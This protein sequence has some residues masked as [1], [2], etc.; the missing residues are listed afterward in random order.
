MNCITTST[1]SFSLNGE[2]V[3]HVQ[4]YRGLRQGDPLSPYLFLIC[5]EGLSRLLRYEEGVGNLDGLRLTRNSPAVSHLLFADDSLLFCRANYQSAVAIHRILDTYHKASGQVLN[6]NKSVMSFSPNTTM[7]AQNFFAHTLHMPIT[8]CHERYL[9]LPSYSG[10]DKQELFSHIKEKVLKLLHAWNEK[11]FSV[12]GK[13]VL[14][15]AVVQSIPTYAM[16]CFKLTNKFC[17][18]LESMMANFWWGTNQ[19]GTKIHWIRWNSL[20]KSK[21]EG[22]MGFRSFFHFNQALL[23]KQAWKIFN[24]PDSLLSRLLKHRYFSTTSF[25]DANIGHSPSYTWQSICWG[26]ELLVKGMRFKIC[27]GHRIVCAT[28]PWIPS[29]TNFKPV[30]YHGPPNMSVS[31]L[32][33]EQ[34]VWNIELLNSFFQPIDV[35]KILTIPLSFFAS[36]D[37]LIWHHSTSGSY[38]VKSGFH[39]ASSLED[40]DA[41]SPSD[42]NLT[43]WKFFWSLNL[44]PKIRIFAWKVYHNIIPTAAALHRRKI[45]DSAACSL[46]TSN[47]E[48]VG[49]ALFD[50]KHARR[51]WQESKFFIDFQ[52]AKAMQNGDYFQLLSSIYSQEDFELLVCI[53]WGVWTDRNKIFHGGQARLSSSIVA[54]AT[55]FHHDYNR[56]KNQSTSMTTTSPSTDRPASSSRRHEQ[57]PWSVPRFNEFKLNIDV[58]SIEIENSRIGPYFGTILVWF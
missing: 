20:C 51:I 33:T 29:H 50:C 21:H 17:N 3:G 30:S 16:S 36:N 5:S 49:H 31:H 38:N 18:Q 7:A 14:L 44:P 13:E 37:R 26:R 52:S 10:R 41:C 22:G 23:A 47:W 54:Y 32:I 40:E 6:N 25:L 27:D 2:V 12:G 42:P 1:F 56:A 43:W 48:S 15:K 45:I 8:E 35:D 28:D 55:G 34:R 4:P 9:G 58:S 46:C 39:L 24:M 57:I 11:I 19:N 53:M